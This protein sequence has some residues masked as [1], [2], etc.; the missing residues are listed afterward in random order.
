M[1]PT[2]ES[3]PFQQTDSPQSLD[4]TPTTF[5]PTLPPLPSVKGRTS[6]PVLNVENNAH[7]FNDPGMTPPSTNF[8]RVETY[9]RPVPPETQPRNYLQQFG[10]GLKNLFKSVSR[11]RLPHQ[12]SAPERNGPFSETGVQPLAQ[13]KRIPLS[14]GGSQQI[15]FEHPDRPQS[16]HLVKLKHPKFLSDSKAPQ[17]LGTQFPR[18]ASPSA[19]NSTLI[20]VPQSQI[21]MCPHHDSGTI[22]GHTPFDTPNTK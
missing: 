17:N 13:Y 22:G 7:R 20:R 4:N 11:R 2:P 19:N 18:Q 9:G 1:V 21:T 10:N 3:K 6:M 14:G 16:V 12:V 15:S 5:L 8:E